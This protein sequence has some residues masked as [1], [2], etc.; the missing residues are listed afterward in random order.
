V[1]RRTRRG[2]ST[3]TR[4]AAPR[5]TDPTGGPAGAGA[6]AG[7]RRL[8][9]G[10][11]GG[12]LVE[13]H[14]GRGLGLGEVTG[15]GPLDSQVSP[16]GLRRAQVVAGRGPGVEEHQAAHQAPGPAPCGCRSDRPSRR[17][18]FLL[19]CAEGA[20][21]GHAEFFRFA[22]HCRSS[23]S[24]V[25]VVERRRQVGVSTLTSTVRPLCGSGRTSGRDGPHARVDRSVVAAVHERLDGSARAVSRPLVDDRQRGPPLEPCGLGVLSWVSGCL[26]GRGTR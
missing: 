19:L 8:W 15:A 13:G 12:R 17:S 21:T 6:G 18:S 26:R 25:D 14:Q 11:P 16:C 4:S 10:V 23:A 5:W 20:V 2:L 7:R 3:T 1:G 22:G 24:S 9:S